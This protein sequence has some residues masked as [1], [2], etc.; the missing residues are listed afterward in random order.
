MISQVSVACDVQWMA[1]GNGLEEALLGRSACFCVPCLPCCNA[2]I[3]CHGCSLHA[4]QVCLLLLRVCR[5]LCSASQQLAVAVGRGSSA[6]ARHV[7]LNNSL[8]ICHLCWG[9]WHAA[10]H[11]CVLVWHMRCVAWRVC[12]SLLLLPLPLL[13]VLF[14][15]C[16]VWTLP[17]PGTR[18]VPLHFHATA[19][20]ALYTQM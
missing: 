18:D 7:G 17:W 3:A 4:A 1:S 6:G 16:A 8:T 19:A 2:A 12:R 13:L 9:A 20:S 5:I 15:S 10:A 11:C 14:L